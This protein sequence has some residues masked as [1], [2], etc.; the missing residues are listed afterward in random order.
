[1]KKK[2]IPVKIPL[3]GNGS[4]YDVL[5]EFIYTMELVTGG[6]VD[7]ECDLQGQITVHYEL[8]E[9]KTSQPSQPNK[10]KSYDPYDI[11][12]LMFPDAEYRNNEKSAPMS[13][14]Q[15]SKKVRG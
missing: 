14:R 6:D 12:K 15:K 13:D 2:K 1:M 9:T 7:L 8:D 4:I 11:E 3:D 10:N 5:N